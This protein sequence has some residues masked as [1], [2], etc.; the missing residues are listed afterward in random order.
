M[1]TRTSIQIEETS[2]AQVQTISS[3]S[4][5]KY[6]LRNKDAFCLGRCASVQN[7]NSSFP[8]VYII[9]LQLI[10][11]PT[12]IFSHTPTHNHSTAGRARQR[13]SNPPALDRAAGDPQRAHTAEQHSASI[14]AVTR[15]VH[16]MYLSTPL[17]FPLPLRCCR[18][19][20]H[21]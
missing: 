14:A 21:S 9:N 12:H 10:A 3:E 6:F 17:P 1:T 20:P 18:L 4:T 16:L 5:G 19:T 13:P 2:L 8:S 11:S 7:I 15:Y